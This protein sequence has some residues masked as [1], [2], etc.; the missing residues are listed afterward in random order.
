MLWT[1]FF[2]LVSFF[3]IV[4][5]IEFVVCIME[6]ISTRTTKSLKELT[7][8]ADIDGTEPHVEFVLSSLRIMA[9]RIAF[10][11]V[12]TQ[13]CIRDLGVDEDTYQ[14]ILDYIEENS[15]I[16]LIEKEK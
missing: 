6:T 1:V 10:K 12:T 4:G 16:Y 2:L 3:A 13:V 7:I 14:R 8:V 9:D 15:G 11:N 5:V